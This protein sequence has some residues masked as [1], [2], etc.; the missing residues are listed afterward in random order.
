MNIECVQLEKAE[1][2]LE[3]LICL[4]NYKRRWARK[5][6]NHQ[7]PQDLG[8]TRGCWVKID[9]IFG[10]EHL[11]NLGPFGILECP[12]QGQELNSII[13]VNPFQI[14]R[15]R[16]ICEELKVLGSHRRNLEW[17]QIAELTLAE[18]ESSFQAFLT[19]VLEM[20]E[21]GLVL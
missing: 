1:Q 6:G 17:L 14:R 5:S 8:S 13:P 3:K 21:P 7:N 9:F 11:E 20:Q 4:R 18:P 15:S 12:V 16:D 10:H 2:R 19:Q